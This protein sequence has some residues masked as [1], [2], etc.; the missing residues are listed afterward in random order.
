MNTKQEAS[1]ESSSIDWL[2]WLVVVALIGGATYGN[3]EYQEQ[4]DLIYRVLI[5]VAVGAIAAF[6]ALQTEKGGRFWKL[7][8]E[9]QIELR[10]VVWPTR[11]ETNRT[12]MVVIVVI[13]I[14]GIFLWLLDMLFQALASQIIG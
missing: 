14:T 11:D 5:W 3:M 9:A 10:K 6:V 7:L 13:I 2:K 4:I 8:K 1:G 12:T